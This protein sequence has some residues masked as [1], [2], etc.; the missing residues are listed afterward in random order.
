M[1]SGEGFSSG[2][3]LQRQY[4]TGKPLYNVVPGAP[5]NIAQ[6]KIQA[7]LSEQQLSSLRLYIY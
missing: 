3:L 7:M 6:E 1:S 5:D 4:C 2:M